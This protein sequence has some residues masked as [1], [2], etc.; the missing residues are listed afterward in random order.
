MYLNH[1]QITGNFSVPAGTKKISLNINFSISDHFYIWNE[2]KKSSRADQCCMRVLQTLWSTQFECDAFS[3]TKII[4]TFFFV[5]KLVKTTN[6][7]LNGMVFFTLLKW[8][9]KNTQA[10]NEKGKFSMNDEGDNEKM[11]WQNVLHARI[12]SHLDWDRQLN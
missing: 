2:E 12:H 11:M 6:Y 4:R 10:N 5:L 3:K 8:L 7:F 1:M 9:F